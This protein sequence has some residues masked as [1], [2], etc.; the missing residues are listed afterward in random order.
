VQTK[1]T[2]GRVARQAGVGIETIRFYERQ[3]LV[4]EPPRGESGY[5]HYPASVVPRLLFIKQ[6]KELGFTLKEIKELLSLRVE[7]SVTC[8]DVK[9]RAEAKIAE[10]EAKIRAL[11][12]IKRALARVT[13]ACRGS[14]PIDDCP[15]LKALG[16]KGITEANGFRAAAVSRTKSR[17]NVPVR[18]VSR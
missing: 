11:K 15:I 9:R 17:S 3:G 8:A 16:S 1:L 7:P 18:D 2:I 5:R 4:V 12:Q 10:I 13:E 14:G 6:A